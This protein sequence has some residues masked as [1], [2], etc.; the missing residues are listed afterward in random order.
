MQAP[1]AILSALETS[2]IACHGSAVIRPGQS[3]HNIVDCLSIARPP[4]SDVAALYLDYK[5]YY[6]GNFADAGSVDHNIVF[7]KLAEVHNAS[8]AYLKY[9][10]T[11]TPSV[12]NLR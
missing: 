10:L 9:L 4:L 3:Q 7:E 6:Q 5:A 8:P 1:Q 11:Q 2:V 12:R